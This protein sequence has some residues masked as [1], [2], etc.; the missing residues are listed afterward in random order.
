MILDSDPSA[1]VVEFVP[2]LPPY[3]LRISLRVLGSSGLAR[4]SA[5]SRWLGSLPFSGNLTESVS[6]ASVCFLQAG[7]SQNLP[8]SRWNWIALPF[9]GAR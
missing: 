4:D 3:R 6:G 8:P 7:L 5:K 1:G 2:F 9:K